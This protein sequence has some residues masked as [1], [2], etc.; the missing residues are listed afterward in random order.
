MCP[1]RRLASWL[2]TLLVLDFASSTRAQQAKW[3]EL[4]THIEE[5]YQRGDYSA[6]IPDEGE[7]LVYDSIL[8]CF[9]NRSAK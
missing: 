2:L 9:L 1:I 5:L 8:S 4:K 3:K 6:A 7:A